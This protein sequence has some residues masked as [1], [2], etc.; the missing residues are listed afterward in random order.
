MSP[1]TASGFRRR[2]LLVAA[3]VVIAVALLAYGP[4][5]SFLEGI[6]RPMQRVP[7]LS[8]E[9]FDLWVGTEVDLMTRHEIDANG[10]GCDVLRS[11]DRLRMTCL[12]A[13]NVDPAVIGASLTS[14]SETERLAAVDALAWRARLDQQPD[15][16]AA[17]G[18]TDV[19]LVDCERLAVSDNYAVRDDGLIVEIRVGMPE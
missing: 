9:G 10:G 7:P 13:T 16:C 2:R 5:V 3:I 4:V 19:P 8:I 1:E 14:P 15:K 18:L 12:L 6:S 11:S 17:G